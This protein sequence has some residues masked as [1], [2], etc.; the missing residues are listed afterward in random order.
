[1]KIGGFQPFSLN[2]YPGHVAAVIYTQGCNL[3]C[4]FCH[5]PSLVLPESF[6]VPFPIEEVITR[7][8]KRIGKID[9]V[10]ISGGEP[11]LQHDLREC[12]K[13]LKNMSLLVKIDT[14]GTQPEVLTSLLEEKLIDFIAMDIKAPQEKYDLLCGVKIS[15]TAIARS[16]KIIKE[17]GIAYQ[18]RTTHYTPFLEDEDI[19]IIR[20]M[21][22]ND[23]HYCLQQ[24][25]EMTPLLATLPTKQAG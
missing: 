7:L 18:F 25:Q 12:I 14:N 21:L 20:E 3:R 4:P 1:M 2:D 10:V 22:G 8:E 11:T 13:R 5:N 16:I 23:R 9:G 19:L 6:G 15:F 17:S 24:Y